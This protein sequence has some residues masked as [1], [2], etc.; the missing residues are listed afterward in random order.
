MVTENNI[1]EDETPQIIYE[2]PT[3]IQRT[4]ICVSCDQTFAN[5]YSLRR[6]MRLIHHAPRTLVYDVGD[7]IMHGYPNFDSGNQ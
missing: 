1:P 6:H 3:F 5:L 2:N 4:W 7:G